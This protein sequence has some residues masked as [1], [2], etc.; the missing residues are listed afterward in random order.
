MPVADLSKATQS[1]KQA[2]LDGRVREERS[3]RFDL[4]TPPF[5]RAHLVRMSSDEWAFFMRQSHIIYDDWSDYVFWSELSS[6]YNS[7]TSGRPSPLPELSFQYVDYAHWQRTTLETHVWDDQIAYWC[8]QLRGC[9]TP[10]L[11]AD[12]ARSETTT[13]RGARQTL[14]MPTSVLQDLRAMSRRHRVTLFMVMVAALCAVLHSHSSQEDIA[15]RTASANRHI[16]GTETLIGWMVNS[17]VLRVDASGNPTFAELLRRVRS[18]AIDSFRNRDI[19]FDT[20]MQQLFP[21]RD[22][23]HDSPFQALLV[24]HESHGG[25]ESQFDD[26]VFSPFDVD[27]PTTHVGF[28]CSLNIGVGPRNL[29]LWLKLVFPI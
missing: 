12:L 19:G 2:A 21:G 22:L 25:G 26:V 16:P 23:V 7:F 3:H 9:D 17:L 18:V 28:D 29:K 13:Q 14:V 24:F 11:P 20:V 6:L 15:I 27:D 4:T 1:E 8:N 10:V 5:L